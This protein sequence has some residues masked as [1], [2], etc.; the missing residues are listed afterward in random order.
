MTKKC[1]K[2]DWIKKDQVEQW[3]GYFGDGIL[4]ECAECGRIIERE[5]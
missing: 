2:C 1:G 5:N 3:V 4:G